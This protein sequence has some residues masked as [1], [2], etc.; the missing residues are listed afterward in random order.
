MNWGE[1]WTMEKKC[2]GFYYGIISTI[3]LWFVFTQSS[4]QNMMKPVHLVTIGHDNDLF[5]V[6][7]KGTDEYY[8]AGIYVRYGFTNSSRK[9]ILRKLLPLPI[10][11]DNSFFSIGITQ[12][13]YTPS[14]LRTTRH[15]TIDYPYSG[16]L[17]AEFSRESIFHQRNLLVSSLWLGVLGPSA[18]GFQTQLLVHKIMALERPKGWDGQLPNY[19]VI[20]YNLSY[21][22]NLTGTGALKIN[23][24]AGVQA[25]SLLNTA[26]A[27]LSFILTDKIDNNFPD[28][29]Y[30]VGYDE[31]FS[32]LKFFI[33]MKPMV[34]YVATNAILEGG[35]FQ[36]KNYYHISP[37]DLERFVASVEASAGIHVKRF[38]VVYKQVF[39]TR[40]IA[41]V[42]GHVYGSIIFGVN[43]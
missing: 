33:E 13:M 37:S 19:P 27:A 12:W 38:S 32:H 36:K 20:N 21:E 24:V 43:F 18:L 34:R 41:E 3:C 40:Q 15:S 16:T 17:F 10:H 39:E 6:L 28:R 1:E 35:L 22:R 9:N 11:S 2:R 29:Y 30:N 42:N 8:T 7:R 31:K 25:G 26:S 23:G 4:A 5:N 14:D